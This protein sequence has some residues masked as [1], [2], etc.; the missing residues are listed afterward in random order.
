MPAR[1]LFARRAPAA[2]PGAE[3]PPAIVPAAP[4]QASSLRPAAR[5]TVGPGSQDDEWLYR[6]RRH[7]RARAD[8]PSTLTRP[9]VR[10]A[11]PDTASASAPVTAAAPGYGRGPEPRDFSAVPARRPAPAR[12]ATARSEKRSLI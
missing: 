6:N 1:F 7:Q 4:T 8:G 10:A 5:W 12:Q 2:I 9:A 11:P 3:R